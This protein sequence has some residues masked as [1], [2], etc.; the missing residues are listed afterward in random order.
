MQKFI[1]TFSLFFTWWILTML[2]PLTG[3][4]MNETAAHY[5]GNRMPVVCYTKDVC[6]MTDD[7]VHTPFTKDTRYKFL[8]DIIPL[9]R[10]D[11]RMDGVESIGDVL[12]FIGWA[13]QPFLFLTFVG[14]VLYSSFKGVKKLLSI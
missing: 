4:I 3:G 10:I 14:Y 1:G 7:S 12:V 5:N 8:S 6:D 2:L 13:C 11:G 9:I